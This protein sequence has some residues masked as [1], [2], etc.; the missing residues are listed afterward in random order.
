MAG[1]A[2]HGGQIQSVVQRALLGAD[3]AAIVRSF[4][5]EGA[6]LCLDVDHPVTDDQATAEADQVTCLRVI[7][8]RGAWWTVRTAQLV[9]V[10]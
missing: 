8:Q 3:A 5:A 9:S 2:D 6:P 4:I 1:G 10:K 7:D